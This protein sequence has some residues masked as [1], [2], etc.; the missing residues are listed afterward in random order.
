MSLAS[1]CA[2]VLSLENIS[3]KILLLWS[4]INSISTSTFPNS[5]Q[6]NKRKLF[7]TCSG[8][9]GKNMYRTNPLSYTAPTFFWR[10]PKI[11]IASNIRWN[12][13][14]WMISLIRIYE[15]LGDLIM[16][17]QSERLTFFSF[18]VSLLFY[19]LHY[20][21]RITMKIRL[22]ACFALSLPYSFPSHQYCH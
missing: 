21:W 3:C 9:I 6:R 2:S 12:T 4:S 17:W 13:T 22:F 15:V 1:F 16:L 20:Y 18:D 8:Y 10:K 11:W 7:L 14:V 5:F 19:L